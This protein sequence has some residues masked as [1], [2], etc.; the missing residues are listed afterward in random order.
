MMQTL[1]AIVDETG[2]I[3]LLE[4]VRL[5]K[6][7]RALVTILDEEPKTAA[8]PKKENLRRVFGEMRKVEMFQVIENVSDWQKNLRDEWE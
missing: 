5:D 4:E 2:K 3:S 1:E 7:R 8:T 6:S